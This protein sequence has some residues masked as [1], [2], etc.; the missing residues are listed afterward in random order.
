MCLLIFTTQV[1][2]VPTD[3]YDAGGRQVQE[4]DGAVLSGDIL[5]LLEAKHSMSKSKVEK[6]ADRIKAFPQKLEQ[7]AQK[8][9]GIMFKKIVGVA[10]GT[11]FPEDSRKE[12]HRLGLM[13][14]YPSG[15]RYLVD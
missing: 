9:L 2:G 14:I 1:E 4:W 12:A 5:Y 7:S 6:M 10:C 15:R 8:D 13:V 3:I 11:D